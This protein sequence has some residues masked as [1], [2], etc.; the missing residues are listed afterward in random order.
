MVCNSPWGLLMCSLHWFLLLS[1]NTFPDCP[2]TSWGDVEGSQEAKWMRP[3]GFEEK[4]GLAVWT[5]A[6]PVCSVSGSANSVWHVLFIDVWLE[7]WKFK[8]ELHRWWLYHIPVITQAFPP[9]IFCL[10]CLLR[11]KLT[12]EGIDTWPLFVEYLVLCGSYLHRF[13]CKQ[14]QW[15]LLLPVCLQLAVFSLTITVLLRKNKG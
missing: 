13:W 7:V 15:N 6:V 10:F 2:V 4:E 11:C 14:R 1:A 12:R 5:E 8:S 9:P 3:L